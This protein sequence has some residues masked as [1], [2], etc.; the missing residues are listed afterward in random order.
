MNSHGIEEAD[1]L[2]ADSVASFLQREYAFAQR[3]SLVRQSQEGGRT[4]AWRRFAELGWLALPVAEEYGGLG[5]PAQDAMALMEEFGR[6]LVLEP[7][8][9]AVLEAGVLL[10][11]LATD[12]QRRQLLPSMAAGEALVLPAHLEGGVRFDAGRVRTTAEA[13]EGDVILRGTKHAVPWGGHADSWLVSARE[14]EGLSLFQVEAGTPGVGITRSIG[15]D[16]TPVADLHLA[17]ARI[18]AGRRLGAPG[19]AGAAIEEAIALATAAAC[20]EAIGTLDRM[21]AI[22]I[23]YAKLRTQF[24]QPIGRFQVTQH[25]L[26]DMYTSIELSRT[27]AAVASAHVAAAPSVR[28][29]VLSAAKAQV[30]ASCR[31]VGEHAIQIHGGIGMTEECEAS[32]CFRRLFALE[33]RLGDRHHHLGELSAAIAAGAPTLYD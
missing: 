2:L 16:D 23:D 7:Y 12:N 30:S 6:H 24:G 27:M 13:V 29:P 3:P 1:R 33:K 28:A 5:Q 22:T 9:S 31:L 25:K 32:H 4:P 14:G 18:P 21:L 20:H 8:A 11:A 15:A 17:G 19:Q 26:V 10:Q